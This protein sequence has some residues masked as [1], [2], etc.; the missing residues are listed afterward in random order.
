MNVKAWNFVELKF[1]V[2]FLQRKSSVNYNFVETEFSA[3][4][5]FHRSQSSLLNVLEDYFLV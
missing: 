3:L 2:Y 4:N 1:T 5:R